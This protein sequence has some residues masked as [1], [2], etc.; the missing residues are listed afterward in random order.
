MKMLFSSFAYFS[1]GSSVSAG[2][3]LGCELISLDAKYRMPCH[4]PSAGFWIPD[5]LVLLVWRSRGFS[6]PDEQGYHIPNVLL[7]PSSKF[8]VSVTT[9]PGVQLDD[10]S[11]G[12]SSSQLLNQVYLNLALGGTCFS[13]SL[14]ILAQ[15]MPLNLRLIT[16]LFYLLTHH[17]LLIKLSYSSFGHTSKPVS[18]HQCKSCSDNTIHC[19]AS[20]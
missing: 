7:S 9:R 10:F 5:Y 20:P 15:T 3:P 4:G 18:T 17:V 2:S 16:W 13:P 6:Y 8:E 19:L 11:V 14:K 1:C 12:C